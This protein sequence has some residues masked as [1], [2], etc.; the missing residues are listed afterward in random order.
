MRPEIALPVAYT[1]FVALLWSTGNMGTGNRN[2][3]RASINAFRDVPITMYK[4]YET[5]SSSREGLS[6]ILKWFNPLGDGLGLNNPYFVIPVVYA[7]LTI[8]QLH[9]HD[10]KQE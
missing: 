6:Y 10:Q 2:V 8:N 1:V 5:A 7:V 4:I 9:G 3:L